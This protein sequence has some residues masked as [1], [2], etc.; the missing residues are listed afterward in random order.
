MNSVFGLGESCYPDLLPFLLMP[1]EYSIEK[2]TN[3]TKRGC[4]FWCALSVSS[5]GGTLSVDRFVGS[6]EVRQQPGA[7]TR[8]GGTDESRRAISRLSCGD[9]RE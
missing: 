8:E 3:K 9:R 7:E 1:S 5:C 2:E 4:V 6:R